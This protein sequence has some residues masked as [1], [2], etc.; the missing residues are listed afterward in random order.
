MLGMPW[1]LLIFAANCLFAGE[2]HILGVAQD[3]GYPQAQ[4]RKTCCIK[5]RRGALAPGL[6]TA[7]GL[8]GDN[9]QRWLFEATPA[10]TEQ[11]S[12]LDKI[13]G[14]QPLDGVFVTH[15]HIGHYTGLM[16]FGREV[17]GS[18]KTPV[19]A[20]PRMQHFL[21]T[22]G[23]W[24]QLIKLD[25]IALHLLHNQLPVPLNDTLTVTPFLV[26]HRDEY[27]ETVGF[28]IKG[29]AKSVLFIPDI[30]KWDAWNTK[31][32]SMI[33]R[34]DYALLDG[35]FYDQSEIPNR[36]MAEIPHPFVVESMER[37]KTLPSSEKRKIYFIHFNHSNPLWQPTSKAYRSVVEAGFK[38]A[39][40]GMVLKLD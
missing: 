3:A 38:V 33:A 29:S 16:Y 14:P 20:M 2:L 8:V 39:R 13:A 35:T 23:P 30:N 40:Q 10:I 34:V 32:E 21:V 5:V 28:I 31:V 12:V 37:F 15:A 26:P 17:M 36:D 1:L 22:N 9:G 24:Q 6:P 25:N 4:C 18:H 7:L 19:F 11:L 27:S